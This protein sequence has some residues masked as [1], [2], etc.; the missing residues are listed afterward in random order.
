MIY[1]PGTRFNPKYVVV[2]IPDTRE[3]PNKTIENVHAKTLGKPNTKIQRKTHSSKPYK[4][5]L[6][7]NLVK[8]NTKCNKKQ[9]YKKHQKI[10]KI[11]THHSHAKCEFRKILERC[12]GRFASQ[13]RLGCKL[14]WQISNGGKRTDSEEGT[15]A[16][17]RSLSA[18]VVRKEITTTKDPLWGDIVLRRRDARK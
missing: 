8:P 11:D 7:K 4:N 12:I 14:L 2:Y 6:P 10:Y 1:L 16:K 5:H 17:V 18:K 13:A 9:P 3:T 15:G